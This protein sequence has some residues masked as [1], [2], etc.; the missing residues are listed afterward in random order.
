MSKNRKISKRIVAWLLF[1]MIF[2]SA[3]SLQATMEST[4]AAYN[5]QKA[6]Q[7]I[8]DTDLQPDR[9]YL[10]EAEIPPVADRPERRTDATETNAGIKA[11]YKTALLAEKE[12]YTTD[13][14]II[15]YKDSAAIPELTESTVQ[16]SLG[17][18]DIESVDVVKT[19]SGSRYAIVTIE[20]QKTVSEFRQAVR[21]ERPGSVIEY[22]QPDY[23]MAMAA[24]SG[25]AM[26]LSRG[27]ESVSPGGSGNGIVVAVLDTGVDITHPD[28]AAQIYVNVGEIPGNGID[29]DG[30]GYIDDVTGWDFFNDNSTV[31]DSAT[32]MDQWHGTHVAGIVATQAPG[33]SILPVKIFEGGMAYTSDILNAIAYAEGMGAKVINCSWGSRYENRALY[34]AIEASSCLFVCAAGN[35]LY[36][37]DNYPVYPAAFSVK[38][39]NVISVASVDGSYKLSRFSNFGMNTADI[40]A[41]GENIESA[42]LNGERQSVSGT[43]MSAGFVSAAAA[44]VFAQYGAYTAADARQ[45][46]ISSADTVTGLV[47][48]II[49]GKMLNAAYAAGSDPRPNSNIIDVPDDDPLP[50]IIPNDF[51]EEDEYELYGAENYVTYKA[52]MNTARHGLHVVGL[53]GK[54]YAIGGQTTTSAGYTNVVERYDPVTDTWAPVANLN[55]A[56]SYFGAVVY[57]GKIYVMGGA[58][59]SGSLSSIESYDPATNLWTTLG[60]TLP[61]AMCSFTA[62]LEPGTSS[63]YIV[64]GYINAQSSE[65]N[66]VYLYDISA[67]TVTQKPSLPKIISNHVSLYSNGKLYIKGGLNSGFTFSQ[68][69]IYDISSGTTSTRPRS[70]MYRRDTA[71]VQING[72]AMCIGGIYSNYYSGYNYSADITNFN[73]SNNSVTYDDS[74]HHINTGRSGLDAA[75]LNGRVYIIGGRNASSALSTVE[76]LDLGWEE[77]AAPPIPVSNYKS[78]NLN[79]KIYVMGGQKQI[80]GNLQDSNTVYEYNPIDNTWR[81]MT[82]LM[83]VYA[84]NFSLV[85]AYGKIYLIGGQTSTTANGSYTSSNKIYEYD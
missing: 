27:S 47:D 63:V 81:T 3:I 18:S 52:S 54:I 56:R 73:I 59:S 13:R 65:T 14:Y 8:L 36:N 69:L 43:S 46:L 85:A 55:T 9:Q 74:D 67:S 49:D 76:M 83:P 30:N 53:G 79:G 11:E 6:W 60:V 72:R 45:R 10:E 12:E 75:Y 68:E 25:G 20:E 38:L 58:G 50:V 71:I 78:V 15:K 33:V 24:A 61:V 26:Q 57:N 77:K 2:I 41:P 28:I 34:E 31:N 40:A 19:A 44:Q 62:T 80:S 23:I 4:R 17:I 16:A 84:K 70:S 39:D 29:D 64:G 35:N 21:P 42:W 5:E 32:Y 66:T 7:E 82:T 48:K 1:I 22:I 51:P 37:M